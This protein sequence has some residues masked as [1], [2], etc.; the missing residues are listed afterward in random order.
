[1]AKVDRRR[2]LLGLAL[3]G[4]LADAASPPPS[5]PPAPP[6]APLFFHLWGELGT[7][8]PVGLSGQTWSAGTMCSTAN[9]S[10]FEGGDGS[11]WSN[12]GEDKW[13]SVLDCQLACAAA[14]C[15]FLVT[16]YKDDSATVWPGGYYKCTGYETCTM[17]SGECCSTCGN[18]C[19]DGRG[20]DGDQIWQR[21]V[22]P[23]PLYELPVDAHV[24]EQRQPPPAH[25]HAPPPTLQDVRHA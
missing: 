17:V 12:L 15:T 21:L 9:G 2:L 20:R 7:S 23:P 14:G 16:R 1:M 19:S 5:P 6:L 4:V 13:A 8:E 11:D 3:L 25:L 18:D 22:P 24:I 10:S